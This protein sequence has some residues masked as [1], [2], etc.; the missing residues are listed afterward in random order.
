MSGWVIMTG[1]EPPGGWETCSR[2]CGVPRSK[3]TSNQTPTWL[4]TSPTVMIVRHSKVNEDSGSDANVSPSESS[5]AMSNPIGYAV[6]RR[7]EG[8]THLNR[9]ITSSTPTCSIRSSPRHANDEGHGGGGGGCG[10]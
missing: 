3:R 5:L 4:P 9:I 10:Q 7:C 1:A 8:D 2:Y 6:G